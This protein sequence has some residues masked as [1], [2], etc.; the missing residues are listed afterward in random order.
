MVADV[1][2]VENDLFEKALSDSLRDFVHITQ[3]KVEQKHC[4]R[5]LVEKKDVFGILPTGFGKSI[6]F[7]ILPRVMK[8]LWNLERTTVLVV[9]PLVSIMKDQVEEMRQLGLKAYAIGL[10][11]E[12]TEK[13]LRASADVEIIYGSPES[14]CSPVWSR[15]LQDGQLGKQIVCIVVDES[16][17]VTDW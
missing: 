8:V 6:I 10:G 16:H 4:L 5:S 17:A 14:W 11:D 2:N 1:E 13:E 9:T 12:E 15:E 7:Q 3:L